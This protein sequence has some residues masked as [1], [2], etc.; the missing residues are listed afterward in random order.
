MS[1]ISVVCLALAAIMLCVGIMT[2]HEFGF[3]KFIVMTLVIILGMLICVFVIMMVFVLIQQLFTFVGTLIN[4]V[5]Y[6]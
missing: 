1:A 6:R 3:F 4:E 5:T 2:V